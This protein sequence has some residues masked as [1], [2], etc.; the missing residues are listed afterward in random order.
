MDGAS[1]S[2]SSSDD[3]LEQLEDDES[4]ERARLFVLGFLLH[5]KRTMGNS[6]IWRGQERLAQTLRRAQYPGIPY[7]VRVSEELSMLG[8]HALTCRFKVQY[9]IA[10]EVLSGRTPSSG[11]RIRFVRFGCAITSRKFCLFLLLLRSAQSLLE[12]SLMAP[13]VQIERA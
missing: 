3:S 9:E 4:R 7:L 10:V 6:M 8:L 2:S 11:A 12:R 13:R 5:C 1:S